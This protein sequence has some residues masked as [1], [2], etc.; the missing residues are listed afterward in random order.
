M[1]WRRKAAENG[2]THMCLTLAAR[3]YLD[4]PYAREVGRVGEAVG[5]SSSEVMEGHDV[6]PDV[7]IGVVHWLQQ[8]GRDPAR[9]LEFYRRTALNGARYC[10]NDGCEVVGQVKEFK[11]CPQ[12]KTVRYCGDA[13]QA[14]DW[15]SGG[16]KATCGT[17]ASKQGQTRAPA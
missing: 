15:T 7:L 10:C 5:V 16:H 9:N 14:Q 3:M 6:P 4:Q 12:C 1:R 2:D 8:G 13:C 17:V 11:V